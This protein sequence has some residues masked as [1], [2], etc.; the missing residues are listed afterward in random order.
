MARDY[1]A[2]KT[3]IWTDPDFHTL[4][5]PAQHL[6]LALLCHPTLTLAGVL[7]WRPGRIANISTTITRTDIETTAHELEQRGYLI[8]DR[9]SEEAFIRSFHRNDGSMKQPNLGTGIANALREVSSPTLH[10]HIT[11]ELW[12]LYNDHPKLK[13]F[14]SGALREYMNQRPEIINNPPDNPPY[15]GANKGP[16]D[17]H[18][19]P[20]DKGPDNP[21][22]E[23][24]PDPEPETPQD[25]QQD[26]SDNPPDNPCAEPRTMNQE[27]RTKNPK[28]SPPDAPRRPAGDPDHFPPLSKLGK[29]NGRYE[30]PAPFKDWWRTYPKHKNGS[31]SE[32]YTEWQK[33]VKD[34]DPDALMD[35]TARFAA[36]PGTS[37]VNFILDADRWLKRRKWETVDET[38]HRSPAQTGHIFGTSPEDWL[39]QDDAPT[40]ATAQIIDLKELGS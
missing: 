22:N 14:N 13:G 4:T 30:Y 18:D 35:I 16:D 15:E 12:R 36:N 11:A 6:Y 32:A 40:H 20:H 19:D 29:T 7:D 39:Y 21:P 23:G 9:D 33:A 2:I 25:P 31:M 27:P 5:P 24:H 17:P 34:I 3:T 28:T 10:T 8:I 1:A 38:D 37:D 26:P